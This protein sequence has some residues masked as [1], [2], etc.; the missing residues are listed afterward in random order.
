MTGASSQDEA[1]SGLQEAGHVLQVVEPRFPECK[2]DLQ[3]L[4]ADIILVDGKESPS[5]G[6]ATVGW[7]ANLAKFRTTPVVFLDA[8]DKDVPK[9]KKEVPRAQF[10]AW[11]SVVQTTERLAKRR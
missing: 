8:S 1:L 4:K 10:A 7:M 11:S 3:G 6:R 5:H 9:A 2:S